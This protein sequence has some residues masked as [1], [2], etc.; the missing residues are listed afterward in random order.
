MHLV[1]GVR[2]GVSTQEL[3]DELLEYL[4]NGSADCDL[5]GGVKQSFCA[6]AI[7]NAVPPIG[8]R[9]HNRCGSRPLRRDMTGI[10]DNRAHC[11]TST[12]A[13]TSDTS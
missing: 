4:R 7:P 10:S 11:R 1:N 9:G 13:S 8:W 2:T 6:E 3:V 12:G 5:F